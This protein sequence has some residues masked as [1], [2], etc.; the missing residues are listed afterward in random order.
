MLLLV[1]QMTWVVTPVSAQDR[2]EP[3]VVEIAFSGIE[4]FSEGELTR[5]I[6]TEATSCRTFAFV[7]P[8]P[9]CPLTD[10]GFAHSRKYLT[11]DELPL[12]MLRLQLF[13]RQRG[14]REATVDTV[15]EREN[16]KARIT[17]LV[18]E[19]DPTVIRVFDVAGTE[20]ILSSGR[21]AELLNIGAG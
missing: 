4:R 17:F 1:A 14:F 10:W 11:Q 8:L 3:E 13:Y 18:D 12:D 2:S 9:F 20:N 5:A 7:F 6:L 19:G 15:V 21:V 16:G